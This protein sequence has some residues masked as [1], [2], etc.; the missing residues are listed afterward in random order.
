MINSIVPRLAEKKIFVV[1]VHDSVLVT[2][3]NTEPVREI[4]MNEFKKYN[5]QPTLK[6]K[7]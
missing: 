3:D 6:I 4:I 2:P 1:T 5:L 7:G